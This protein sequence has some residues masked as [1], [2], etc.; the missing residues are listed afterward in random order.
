MPKKAKRFFLNGHLHRVIHQNRGQNVVTA[1]DFVD[2]KI[3]VYPYSEVESQKENAFNLKE[4]G[5]ILSRN[6]V[7]LMR[8][9][10]KLGWELQQEH[11]LDSN[12]PGAYYLSET[13]VMK[14]R[15]FMSTVHRGRP[16]TDGRTTNSRVPTREEVRTMI[17]SGRVLYVKEN[18]EFVPV[19]KA[20]DW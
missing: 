19:W 5:R 2:N 13:Q 20:R 8:Y 9:F 1:Y 6:R 16:R 10:D 4:V 14:L 12:I 11:S 7:S 15:D 18:D 3:K 17:Q